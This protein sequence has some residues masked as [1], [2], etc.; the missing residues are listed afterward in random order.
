MEHDS[1]P[2]V[3]QHVFDDI[4]WFDAANVTVE[5]NSKYSIYGAFKSLDLF[6]KK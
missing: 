6:S 2:L 3:K 1:F 4:L 5:G